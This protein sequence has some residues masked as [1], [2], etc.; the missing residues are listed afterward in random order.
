MDRLCL[1]WLKINARRNTQQ[2]ACA[3]STQA[4][5]YLLDVT[6]KRGN[7]R[8]RRRKRNA[9]NRS[10]CKRFCSGGGRWIR[11]TEVT[12]NRFTVWNP[13]Y[14]QGLHCV[15][16]CCQMPFGFSGLSLFPRHIRRTPRTATDSYVKRAYPAPLIA[17]WI[18]ST[19]RG[20]KRW[21]PSVA[22]NDLMKPSFKNSSCIL[23]IICYN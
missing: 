22:M 14:Y 10:D 1:C 2:S 17:I 23:I 6:I 11:T 4:V 12:D 21:V 19:G 5:R 15:R 3:G 16:R 7:P 20:I 9:C 8:E 18:S 13:R